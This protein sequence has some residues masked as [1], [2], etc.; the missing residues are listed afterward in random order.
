MNIQRWALCVV[1]VVVTGRAPLAAQAPPSFIVPAS[2]TLSAADGAREPQAPILAASAQ[3]EQAAPPKDPD[4]AKKGGKQK[5]DKAK[6]EAAGAEPEADKPAKAKPNGFVWDNRPSLRFGKNFR[7]D[8]RLKLQGDIRGSE[9]DLSDVGGQAEFTRKRFG[10]KGTVFKAFEY[11]VERELAS[12]GPWRD[13]YLNVNFVS[14]AQAQGGKFKI[15]FSS[16]E[17][18]GPTDLDFVFRARVVD[19]IAPARSVGGMA[20]G[21]LFKK[22]VHYQVGWFQDDG[23]NPK[24]LQPPPL[25]PGEQPGVR[26]PSYAVRVR[27]APFRSSGSKALKNFEVGGAMVDTTVPEGMNNLQ[28]RSVFDGHFFPRSVYTRGPRRRT[29]FEMNWTPGPASVRAEYIKSTEAR[30]GQ[31]VGTATQLDHDLPELVGRGWYVSGT[32]VLTGEK[33]DGGVTPKKPLFQGG[34]GAVQVGARYETLWFGT[35]SATGPASTSPRAE[36]VPENSDTVTTIG[37]NW[38]ANRWVRVQ[39]NWISEKFLDPSRSPVPGQAT[40]KSWVC[41]LQFVL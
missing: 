31:G 3:T 17:L 14:Y 40:V 24:S 33:T 23:E 4:K 13:V 9:Q 10:V 34:F 35:P 37:V 25:L 20:H 41:R 16:E 6:T 12:G 39:L 38:S 32:Y 22:V 7:M 15:P 26:E 21:G 1:G 29:G 18:T 30:E 36:N 8:F 5:K 28:G 19:A 11:E 27:V 2:F